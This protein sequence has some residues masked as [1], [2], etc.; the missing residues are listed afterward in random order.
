LLGSGL[1][2]RIGVSLSKSKLTIIRSRRPAIAGA[3]SQA[4]E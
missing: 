2:P 1:R 4:E 3:L